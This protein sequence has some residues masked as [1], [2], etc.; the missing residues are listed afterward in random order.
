MVTN[1]LNIYGVSLFPIYMIILK[2][3]G[4]MDVHM[5]PSVHHKTNKIIEEKYK[6]NYFL[7]YHSS[8]LIAAL[9]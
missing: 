6:E 3:R 1:R 4:R 9:C 7:F 8:V 2:I 5:R